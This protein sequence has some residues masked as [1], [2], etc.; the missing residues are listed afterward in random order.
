MDF[1][2]NTFRNVNLCKNKYLLRTKI[3]KYKKED[4]ENFKISDSENRLGKL[5]NK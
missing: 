2:E 3:G 5:I 4:N 1:Y